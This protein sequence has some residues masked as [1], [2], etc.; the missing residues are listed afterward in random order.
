M[1]RARRGGSNGI[2]KGNMKVFAMFAFVS[3]GGG[4]CSQMFCERFINI[5]A[6]NNNRKR[7]KPN[8]KIIQN[9]NEVE[10]L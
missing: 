9:S 7:A 6:N 3:G 1:I 8:A 4:D 5:F 2:K 10:R